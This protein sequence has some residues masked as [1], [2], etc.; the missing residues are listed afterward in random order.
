MKTTLILLS[1]LFVGFTSKNYSVSPKGKY[2]VKSSTASDKLPS[3]MA[4]VKFELKFNPACKNSTVKLA[5]DG[6]A[7]Q[8][9]ATIKTPRMNTMVKKG[10]HIFQLFSSTC[11]TVTTQTMDLTEKTSTII[12]VEF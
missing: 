5:V 1:L 10:K 11:D 7:V 9:S 12:E 6:L 4:Q 8:K 3:G 2:T